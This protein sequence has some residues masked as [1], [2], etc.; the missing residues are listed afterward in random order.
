MNTDFGGDV[1]RMLA[2]QEPE[3]TSFYAA[4]IENNSA[5]FTQRLE[6]L[7]NTPVSHIATT[8]II[9]VDVNNSMAHICEVLVNHHVKKVPVMSQGRMVGMLNRTNILHCVLNQYPDA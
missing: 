1:L 2:D 8:K 6:K 7:L 4:V 3:F 5:S 9:S